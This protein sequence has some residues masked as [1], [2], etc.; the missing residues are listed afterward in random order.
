MAMDALMNMT[1][2]TSYPAASGQSEAP[3]RTPRSFA[4]LRSFS[5]SL[6]LSVS[7]VAK[8][9]QSKTSPASTRLDMTKASDVYDPDDESAHPQQ[10][11]PSPSGSVEA[12]ST[13]TDSADLSTLPDP[14]MKFSEPK[15]SQ[16]EAT[17]A[18]ENEVTT[19]SNKLIGAINHQTV[20]DNALTETREEL[21]RAKESIHRLEGVV[22]KQREMLSGDV[23]I[24][25]KAYEAEKCDLIAKIGE[26][27][28]LRLDVESEK[29]AMERELEQLS[30]ALFEEANNLVI[31]AK[32]EAQRE[33]D[34]IL[35]KNDQLKAQVAETE[36]LLRFQQ[37][38]LAELKHL[39]EQMKIE[40][41]D[42]ASSATTTSSPRSSHVYSSREDLPS[43]TAPS[44]FLSPT[45]QSHTVA[46]ASPT[47]LTHLITP[48]LR[49]DLGVFEDFKTLLNISHNYTNRLSGGSFFGNTSMTGASLNLGSM[50]GGVTSSAASILSSAASV[51]STASTTAASMPHLKDLKFFKRVLV[52]DIEP[53]LRL[54]L[55]PS[56][57]WLARRSVI[58]AIMEGSLVIEPVHSN[59]PLTSV[60]HPHYYS[61][62][63]CGESR[64]SA[65]FLRTHRFRISETDSAQ[66]YPLCSYCLTR[67]RTTCEFMGFL[68]ILK[69]G[70]WRSEDPEDEKAAW[71]ESVRLRE[72]MFWA[73]IGG[74]VVP[75][76]HH[77]FVD[78]GR[79]PRI[80]VDQDH[81]KTGLIEPDEDADVISVIEHNSELCTESPSAT[82][83]TSATDNDTDDDDDGAS[84][85]SS[86][87]DETDETSAS[88]TDAEPPVRE[89]SI[90]TKND[91]DLPDLTVAAQDYSDV[92]FSLTESS[93]APSVSGD[94]I[95]DGQVCVHQAQSAVNKEAV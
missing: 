3:S 54:D 36:N 49:T 35:K 70:H 27:K 51:H 78:G 82:K 56:L 71:E 40:R 94:K 33:H 65:E 5:Q 32:E 95:G 62:S 59:E 53:T 38:Q 4:H 47:T 69:D 66:R 11:P 28:K 92:S 24:R 57:S 6:S 63:L 9:S 93:P 88:E 12:P 1:A 77:Q 81:S 41:E 19:L 8:Q 86:K 42:Q 22:T 76:Q 17:V 79:S 61:C 84:V 46:P 7:G 30:T 43:T 60:I 89:A 80:S 75:V 29:K 87:Y 67:M 73:R 15:D 85:S 34:I 44:N 83:I 74:G 55:S 16:S 58:T 23:W 2:W 37:D 91:T 20:L 21:S 52:E 31:V 10:S 18:L 72:Q 39:M 90:K 45:D 26:E 68:R 64:K 48:V 14:R 25:K 50:T 13:P